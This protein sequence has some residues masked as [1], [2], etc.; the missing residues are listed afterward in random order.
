MPDRV[1]GVNIEPSADDGAA[2]SDK[3]QLQGSLEE[4]EAPRP[5]YLVDDDKEDMSWPSLVNRIVSDE[6]KTRRLGYLLQVLTVG[7]IA[8]VG[9]FYVVTYRAPFEVKYGIAGG[10]M[11][12]ISFG[13]ALLHRVSNSRTRKN[14]PNNC[15]GRAKRSARASH[16]DEP[17]PRPRRAEPG[18]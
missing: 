14:M 16:H 1:V 8:L 11:V 4:P 9:L 10:S 13:R 2:R 18:G 17:R 12:L 15:A 3:T 5:Y 7:I 6:E